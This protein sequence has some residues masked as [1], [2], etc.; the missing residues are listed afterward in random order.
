MER[1]RFLK[2]ENLNV[3]IQNVEILKAEILKKDLTD[4]KDPAQNCFAGDT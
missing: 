3:E 2:S 4:L 1:V